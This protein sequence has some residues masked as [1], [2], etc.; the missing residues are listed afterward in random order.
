MYSD[1]KIQPKEYERIP[2]KLKQKR[3]YCELSWWLGQNCAVS[4]W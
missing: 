3:M 2:S 1:K 4:V